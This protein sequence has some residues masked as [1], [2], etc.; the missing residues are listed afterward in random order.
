MSVA[1]F[2]TPRPGG[3]GARLE[4]SGTQN[5]QRPAPVMTGFRTPALSRAG[6]CS[7]VA[8]VS[9][10]RRPGW[11]RFSRWGCLPVTSCGRD[12]W[13][14]WTGGPPWARWKRPSSSERAPP[15]TAPRRGKRLTLPGAL[16]AACAF[17]ERAELPRSAPPWTRRAPG[18][19][20]PMQQELSLQL[21]RSFA[22]GGFAE[23][24]IRLAVDKRISFDA[25][26]AKTEESS[27][28]GRL[29]F[30][31]AWVETSIGLSWSAG[32]GAVATARLQAQ[33]MDWVTIRLGVAWSDQDQACSLDMGCTITAAGARLS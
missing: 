13:L 26:G 24:G 15:A 31:V 18:R 9:V 29:T 27:C 3:R 20:I 22:V 19:V 5:R 12:G 28:S 17:R 25:R 6:R 4:Y 2:S 30:S 21:D 33:P 14:S 7:V 23:T 11:R 16:R 32:S 8:G 10:L 1:P